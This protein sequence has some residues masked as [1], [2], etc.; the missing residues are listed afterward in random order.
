MNLLDSNP[1][2]PDDRDGALPH[3]LPTPE[4]DPLDA[5]SRAVTRAVD[6]VGPSVVA[7]EV[8]RRAPSRS[9]AVRRPP[10]SGAG[11][12]SGF[13]FTPGE[14]I[15]KLAALVPAPRAHLVRYHGIL[16]PAARARRNVIPC[17]EKGSQTPDPACA[18]PESPR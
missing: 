17:P 9:D 16:G 2:G 8:K 13:V 7:I 6:V 18:N 15:E 11:S 3:V 10:S 4:G 12:G 14:L 5:Y 1:R